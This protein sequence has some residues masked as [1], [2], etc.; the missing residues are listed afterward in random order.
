MDRGRGGGRESPRFLDPIVAP[1]EGEGILPF[2]HCLVIFLMC[3]KRASDRDIWLL[4]ALRSDYIC[5]I[6][7]LMVSQFLFCL[8]YVN[9]GSLLF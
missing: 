7:V 6:Y 9:P 5:E 2:F 1:F 3:V 8:S 4:N